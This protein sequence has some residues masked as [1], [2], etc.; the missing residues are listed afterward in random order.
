[1]IRYALRCDQGHEFESWFPSFEAYESQQRRQLVACPLCGSTG[2]T[3]QLMAPSISHGARA[4]EGPAA[5]APAPP[6]QPVALMAPEDVELRAKLRA[7][8]AEMTANSDYVGLQFS[9]EAR[10]MHSGEIERRSIWGEATAAD[11]R[12]LVEEGIE[13][14]PLPPAFEDRN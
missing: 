6:A 7:L 14:M 4:A 13:V 1:V 12:A 9:D 2:I 11:A 3:K 5:E 8:R 10:R